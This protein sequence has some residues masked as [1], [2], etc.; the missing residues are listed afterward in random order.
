MKAIILA[1]GEGKRLRPLTYG[2]PKP[3]LP[4]GGRPVIDYVLDNIAKCR[5]IDIVYVAVSHMRSALEAYLAHSNFNNFK[6]ETVTTMGWETGGD[7]KTVLVQKEIRNEPILV[8]YGDNVTMIDT[9]KLVDAHR[10]QKNANATV[11][12]FEVSKRDASRF[13]IADLK[14]DR[15]EKFVEKPTNESSRS[16]LANAGYFMLESPT[17]ERIPMGRFKLESE[18]FPA[19]AAAG[20]LFGQI[21]KVK[22]WIDIGTIESYREANR[23]VETILPPPEVRK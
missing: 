19:W 7:L 15:I 17:I 22:L 9:Q 12:L 3:L 11:A 14:G 21:Q 10:K 8:C 1:A 2:I 16:C 6:I 4:V 23:L 18:Y 20:V 5:E 13:G